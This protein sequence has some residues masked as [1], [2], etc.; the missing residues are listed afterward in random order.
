MICTSLG[1]TFTPSEF[2]RCL[3]T[4]KYRGKSFV[5]YNLKYDSGALVQSLPI[6]YLRE[7]QKYDTVKFDGYVFKTIGNKC[8]TVRRGRN[9]IHIYD[10]YNFYLHSLQYNAEKY[11]SSSKENI[12]TLD[13]TQAYVNTHWKDI[14]KYCIQDSLIV[15]QLADLIIKKF[16][17]FDVYPRKLY[18]VAYISYQYFNLKCKYPVVKRY[19][20]HHKHVLGMAME[21]YQGGKFEVTRK[22]SGYLYEYDIISA[23]PAEIAGLIDVTNAR[24]TRSPKYH[25]NAVYGFIR[26]VMNIPM[27]LHTPVVRMRGTVNAYPCGV[28]ER[29]I[30]KCEYE[31]LIKKGVEIKILE[32]V[33]LHINSKIYPFKKEIEKLVKLKQI[34]KREGKELD[35]HTIKIFLNSLYG[36]FVQLIKQGKRYKASACWNPI[37]GT[38]ITARVRTHISDMQNKHKSVIAVHTDSIISTKKL[39]FENENV[40]GS[41][42]P[43]IE[44]NGCIVGS[45]VYQIGGKTAIRGYRVKTPLMDIIDVPTRKVH[46]KSVHA[47]TWREIAFRGWTPEMINRFDDEVK[48]IDVQ[49]DSKRLWLDDYKK[50]SDIFKRPVYSVPLISGELW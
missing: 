3:F 14:S 8:F 6:E 13:F 39:P 38:E 21:S 25:K 24:V 44:G 23:Y 20:E 27:G 32:G 2:P 9:S 1:D 28:I 34:Y 49:F 37:F 30:T 16:E 48:Y 19:W 26:C 31:Y 22:M 11:L 17:H 47:Y 7:L 40:L 43:E 42:V 35:L 50:F 5:A 36:K 45:G 4:R 29:V 10:M 18:S 41:M 15:K 33:W 12:P 46:I